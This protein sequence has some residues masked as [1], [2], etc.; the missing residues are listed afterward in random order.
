[1][2]PERSWKWGGGH[3]SGAKVGGTDPVRSAGKNF[4]GRAPP[5]FGSKSTISRL[6]SDFVI[7]STVWSVY[8]LLFSYSRCPLV[9][10]HL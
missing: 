6:V 5:L 3:R 1:V 4:F 8:C 9:P 2:A 10:S 7:V